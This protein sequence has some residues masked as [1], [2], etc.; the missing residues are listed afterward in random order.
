MVDCLTPTPLSES[1]EVGASVGPSLWR[2]KRERSLSWHGSATVTG[3]G[4]KDDDM[5]SMWEAVVRQLQKSVSNSPFYFLFMS[6]VNTCSDFA[7]LPKA[8]CIHCIYFCDRFSPC[9]AV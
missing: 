3:E 5:E 7:V 6:T 8:F 1:K 4:G 9:V 2:K